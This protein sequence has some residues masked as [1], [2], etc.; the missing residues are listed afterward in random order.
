MP[1]DRLQAAV[2]ADQVAANVAPIV[3]DLQS[4][5]AGGPSDGLA[6]AIRGRMAADCDPR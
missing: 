2:E 3:G 1:E 5:A 6:A 4:Q